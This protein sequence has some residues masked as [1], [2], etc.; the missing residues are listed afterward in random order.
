MKQYAMKTYGVIDDTGWKRVVSF[1]SLILPR[2]NTPGT[3]WIGGWVCIPK[4][5]YI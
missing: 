4:F 1:T 2:E 3:H 5:E